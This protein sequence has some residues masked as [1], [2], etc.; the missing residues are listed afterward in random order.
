M[1]R[2]SQE[3]KFFKKSYACKYLMLLFS[4][5][6]LHRPGLWQRVYTPTG[7]WGPQPGSVQQCKEKSCS[8][9]PLL[10]TWPS[11][12]HWTWTTMAFFF[13]TLNPPNVLQV[14]PALLEHCGVYQWRGHHRSPLFSLLVPSQ[15]LAWGKQG[16][17]MQLKD[18]KDWSVSVSLSHT[19]SILL[20]CIL[21][22]FASF[23]AYYKPCLVRIFVLF[24][25]ASP[26]SETKSG[27]QVT[28]TY[29][30]VLYPSQV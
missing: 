9:I 24:T 5:V 11:L 10:G 15:D 29:L 8:L 18:L 25:V 28:L 17:H 19:C 2:M 14:L 27:M 13:V 3:C 22:F 23:H 6:P 4:E 7:E 26:K 20:I 30:W 21:F 12:S 1:L 16:L